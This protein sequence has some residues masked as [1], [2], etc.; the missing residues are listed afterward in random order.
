MVLRRQSWRE[1]REA[2]AFAELLILWV[3]KQA[4]GGGSAPTV[5]QQGLQ[6]S[7]AHVNLANILSYINYIYF[8]IKT[9]ESFFT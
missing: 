7:A 6:S 3:G 9:N 5:G 1:F 4:R 2:G 8:K